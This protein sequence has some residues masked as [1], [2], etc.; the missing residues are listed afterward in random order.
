MV[1][2]DQPENIKVRSKGKDDQAFYFLEDIHHP[3]PPN[4]EKSEYLD[5]SPNCFF[6]VC[7]LLFF[8]CLFKFFFPLTLTI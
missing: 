5:A 2:E 4:K 3:C 6:T 8:S 1:I 7:M